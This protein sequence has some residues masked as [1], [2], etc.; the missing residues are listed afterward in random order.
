MVA[1]SKVARS[2]SAGLFPDLSVKAPVGRKRPKP[3]GPL[4]TRMVKL[5]C[6]DCGMIIRTTR[7]WIAE[8]GEPY[9][10]TCGGR[11]HIM[12]PGEEFEVE[13]E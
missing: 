7:K 11:F 12:L 5:I 6:K 3:T 8:S 10:G 1:R 4:I 2:R 13:E 9:C